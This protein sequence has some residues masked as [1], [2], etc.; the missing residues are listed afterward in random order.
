MTPGKNRGLT[1]LGKVLVVNTLV[2]SLLTYKMAVLPALPNKI[3]RTIEEYVTKFLWN[4]KKAKIPLK[5]LQV[6]KN[7]GGLALSDLRAKDDSIKCNWIKILKTESAYAQMVY[8]EICPSLGEL[9][10]SCTLKEKNVDEIGI[11]SCFWSD[12]VKAWARYLEK[13][14]LVVENQII[15]YNSYIT[16][17]SKII[18]WKKCISKGLIYVKQ[19]YEF[20]RDYVFL[21]EKYALTKME[22]NMLYAAIPKEWAE[23]FEKDT[24]Q[25]FPLHPH[26][27]DIL[28]AKN[29]VAREVYGTLKNDRSFIVN[30]AKKWTCELEYEI[31]STIL[32]K[33]IKNIYVITNAIKLRSFQYRLLVKG[34]VTN[35]HLEKWKVL[36]SNLCTFCGSN[37]ETVI[38]LFC[39]CV[40][41]TQFWEQLKK[42]L[43]SRFKISVN[44]N[45]SSSTV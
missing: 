23:V 19:M 21:H 5:L 39:E 42:Y 8:A 24:N 17:N 3:I 4:G 33:A 13:T 7:A 31:S 10:W 27:Y 34:V 28:Q 43:L 32:V 15:W 1:L 44:T 41:I 16:V 37:A 29:K 2:S 40:Y 38:H 26:Q 11:K 6:S 30:K 36:D 20:P 9:I 12:V 18:M 22:C 25:Y 35:V 14:Q 45:I